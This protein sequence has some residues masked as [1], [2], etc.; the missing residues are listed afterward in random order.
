MEIARPIAE[1]PN[2]GQDHMWNMQNTDME[3]QRPLLDAEPLGDQTGAMR[4]MFHGTMCDVH[5][6]KVPIGCQ[7][8]S[9]MVPTMLALSPS[10]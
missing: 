8:R 3:A 1:C 9:Q 5:A 2:C 6:I 10:L 4:A 7:Q